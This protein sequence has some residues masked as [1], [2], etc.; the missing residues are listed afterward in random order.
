[1]RDVIKRRFSFQG[2]IGRRQYWIA[3]LIYSI[4]WVLGA[5]ILVVLAALNYNPP[6]DTVTGFTIAGFVVLGIAAIALAFVTVTGLASSGVRRLHDRGKTGYWLLPYYLLPSMM[7]KNVG[8]DGGGLVAGLVIAGIILW[9]IV[10]LGMLSGEAG[11]NGFGP[12]PL[13]KNP[14][15]PPLP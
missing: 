4:A 3:T 7:S 14:A 2:R 12:D 5:A 9:A 13:A 1:M 8:L 10:D 6:D 11:S 15:P